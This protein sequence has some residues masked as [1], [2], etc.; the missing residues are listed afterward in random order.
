[1]SSEVEI[2][3]L[4]LDAM[5]ARATISSFSESSAEARAI[6]RQYAPCRDEILG[7]AHWNFARKQVSLTLLRD[8]TATPAGA[9]PQPWLYEYV[10]PSDCIQA[11]YVM[12]QVQA[13]QASGAAAP[14]IPEWIGAPVRFIISSDVD[15]SGNP[16][17]VLLCNQTQAVLVY[18]MRVTNP[19]LFDA[20]FTQALAALIAS[21]IAFTLTGDKALARDKF[22][23][24]DAITKSA[25]ASNGNEGLTIM[26][27]IPD[28][29]RVRGD[30]SDFGYPDGSFWSVQ[31]QNLTA[32]T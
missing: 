1:M 7:A 26:D 6:S 29:L 32:I 21:R 27:N 5:G 4:A 2:G 13:G 22:Q 17:N 16:I 11:R 8:A 9:V 19:Q 18:T 20:S 31:P 15:G 3:N 28:W 14:A 30:A 24:A 12:P 10:Y 23:M 25:R